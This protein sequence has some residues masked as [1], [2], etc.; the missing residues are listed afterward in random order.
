MPEPSSEG[1]TRLVVVAAHPGD[2]TVAVGGLMAVAAR[3]GLEVVVVL[4]TDE[5]ASSP[6]SLT[7][8][9]GRR[10]V[11]SAA[12]RVEAAGPAV[13]RLA[14]SGTEHRLGLPH[15]TVRDHEDDVVT[16][17]VDVVGED[18]PDTVLVAPWRDDGQADHDAAGRAAA[19]AA[20]RCDATLWEYPLWL[21]HRRD[22]AQAPWADF[23]LLPLPDDVQAAKDSAVGHRRADVDRP[24]DPIGDES[25]PDVDVVAHARGP[26]EVFMR[27]GVA[28]DD[29]LDRL[30]DAVDDPWQVRTSWYEQ[31]KRLV[32]LSAL[33]HPRYGRALEVGGS[34]G[35]LAA[36]L[37]RRCDE[38]VV[39][40]ESAAATASAR[41]ALSGGAGAAPA[42]HDPD[43]V[44]DR[45]RVRVLRASVP[46]QWPSGRFDLVVV[47]EVGYFLG[48]E[49]L[50]RLVARVGTA[51]ADDGVVVLCHWRHPVRGWP[52]D[53]ARVHEIWQEESALPVVATHLEAD[54]RLDVFSRTSAH[55]AAP[56]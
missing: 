48:P 23:H 22:P 29:S 26:F 20:R 34:V 7:T 17:L 35:A 9:D 36:D 33:P 10:A 37:A 15:G 4:L 45:G 39:V 2:E 21:W 44:R 1:A 16:A 24:S 50:R 8:R 3:A 13:H 55:L 18:G 11:R 49:R 52:L 5:E 19:V 46:E 30:H 31:R 43:L 42:A 53:G 47:S 40:D 6:G 38:L 32:T 25:G 41:A 56:E 28:P 27:L 51:L 54:F 14:P 12:R